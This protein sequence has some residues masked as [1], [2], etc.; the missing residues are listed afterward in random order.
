MSQIILL[1]LAHGFSLDHDQLKTCLK[2][3]LQEQWQLGLSVAGNTLTA[4]KIKQRLFVA[5]RVFSAMSRNLTLQQD[6]QMQEDAQ[7]KV[8]TEK[9]PRESR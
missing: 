4:E 6:S 3:L 5:Q 7:N 9:V 2:S 1:I 8:Q